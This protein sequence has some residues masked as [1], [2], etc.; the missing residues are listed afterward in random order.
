M[1]A[2]QVMTC[3][4]QLTIKQRLTSRRSR[5]EAMAGIPFFHTVVY[6]CFQNR[7]DSPIG[8]V[9]HCQMQVVRGCLNLFS[10]NASMYVQMSILFHCTIL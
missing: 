9:A 7:F 2:T 3:E 4:Q 6:L 10:A 1:K 5:L 8:I